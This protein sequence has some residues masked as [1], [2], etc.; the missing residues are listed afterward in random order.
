MVEKLEVPKSK[1][2]SV[3]HERPQGWGACQEYPEVGLPRLHR[4]LHRGVYMR[5]PKEVLSSPKAVAPMGATLAL[6]GCNRG[7]QPSA[8]TRIP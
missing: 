8:G 3:I 2:M 4:P 6:R 1:P 7:A 5:V